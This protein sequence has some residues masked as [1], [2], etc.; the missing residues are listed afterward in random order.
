MKMYAGNKTSMQA[1]TYPQD[2]DGYPID[3][4]YGASFLAPSPDLRR[5]DLL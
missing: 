1:V 5:T 3:T 4:N 2:G